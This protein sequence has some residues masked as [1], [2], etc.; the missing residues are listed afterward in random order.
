ERR[1]SPFVRRTF[2]TRWRKHVKHRTPRQTRGQ[3]VYFHDTFATYIFPR[4]G[5]AAVKLLEAAGFDVIVEE[6]RACCGRPMLSKGLVADAKKV[7]RRNVALLAPYA[8]RGI[9][10]IGTEP[11]CILTLRDEY[12]D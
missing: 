2:V 8:K 6:R 9:P 4:I 1:L 10:I 12:R 3:V 11:S 7:A 5:M